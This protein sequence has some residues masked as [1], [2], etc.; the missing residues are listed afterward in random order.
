MASLLGRADATLVQAAKDMAMADVPADMSGIYAKRAENLQAFSE[1]IQE[2]WDSQFE[3]FNAY[4]TR[5]LDK[6]D[7]VLANGLEGKTN[8]SMIAEVDRET[9]EIKD[10][11]KTFDKR[12]KGNLEWKK[13]EARLNKLAIT[14]KDNDKTWNALV[15]ATANGDLLT[16][17]LDPDKLD[18]YEAMVDDYNNNTNLTNGKIVD[19]D[20][21][22]SLPGKPEVTM[23]WK[24][25]QKDLTVKDATAPSGVMTIFSNIQKNAKT[26]KRPWN[27]E[28]KTDTRNSIINHLKSPN[29]RRNVISERFPGME[30][31]FMEAV[32]GK[33]PELQGQIYDAL[34][35]IG[36]DI[37]NDGVK[38]DKTTYANTDNIVALQK[39]IINNANSKDL[40]A[41][42]LTNN[43]GEKQYGLG[44]NDRGGNDSGDTD[45]DTDTDIAA[46]KY[47]KEVGQGMRIGPN[48]RYYKGITL[49]DLHNDFISGKVDFE[50]Y[51]Y[52]FNDGVWSGENLNE[53]ENPD[54]NI[55]EIGNT[56]T[57]VRNKFGI[58]N[59]FW[60]QA[61]IS[62]GQEEYDVASGEKI[63]VVAKD[64]S[65]IGID[66]T[67]KL[68]NNIFD[69][70]EGAAAVELRKIIG[71]N[72]D[73]DERVGGRDVLRIRT[74]EGDPINIVAVKKVDG[75]WVP[76]TDDNGNYVYKDRIQTDFKESNLSRKTKEMMSFYYTFADKKSAHYDKN[77]FSTA[78]LD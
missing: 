8:D 65:F 54:G 14:T 27:D 75:K 44:K 59:P 64:P 61:E 10:I 55:E 48:D 9:R 62:A 43:I 42:F 22:Y 69:K 46:N 34:M 39:E 41:N 53:K 19:G 58:R 60:T 11:M 21:V 4:E 28:Y 36:T 38:D 29:D 32:T 6:S 26:S 20:F 15:S 24:E 77:I 49:K 45:T 25:L 12:D 67:T 47:W 72:Y 74:I 35:A 7:L 68:R 30:Y 18:L 16:T 2:A 5:M 76:Q 56:E 71:G 23:T 17:T 51:S 31:S 63:E 40:I 78:E 1:G 33:D 37:D 13:L 3:A 52:T 57:F 66:N 73:I 70:N 50:G